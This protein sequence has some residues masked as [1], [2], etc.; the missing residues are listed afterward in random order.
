MELHGWDREVKDRGRLLN[1]NSVK[2]RERMNSFEKGR[3]VNCVCI[4]VTS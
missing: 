2:L 3:H 4:C 1:N